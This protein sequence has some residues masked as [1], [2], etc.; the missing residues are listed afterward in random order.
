[1]RLLVSVRSPDEVAAALGGGA[2]IIDAKDPARGVLGP[3]AGD[4]LQAI[5]RRV[6]DRFPLSIALGDV[7]TVASIDAAVS[8]L[9]V[10]RRATVYVKLGLA[11]PGRKLPLLLSAAVRAC[12]RHPASPRFIG[13]AY[14][15]RQGGGAA[16][17][18]LEAVADAGA[19][20]ILL[21]TSAKDGR[22]LLDVWPVELLYDWVRAGRG[23]GLEVALAG[24]LGLLELGRIVAL[25]PDI[26]GVRGAACA[27]GRT[28]SVEAVRVRAL[29]AR[30]PMD[31]ATIAANH[32]PARAH[33]PAS[34][35]SK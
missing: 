17:E 29:R 14:A 5:D 10:R 7:M 8:A 4:V 30:L 6:P 22:T 26:V 16:R 19:A 2:D 15:D 35:I 23:A 24:S 1:M 33:G 11:D 21:D 27:D 12:A 34:S 25:D 20:G 32:Q 18:V 28:G 3:V 31:P 9:R 13:V